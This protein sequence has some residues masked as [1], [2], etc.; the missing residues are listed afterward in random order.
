MRRCTIREEKSLEQCVGLLFHESG[1]LIS[2]QKEVTGVSTFGFKDATWMSTSLLCEQ[3]CQITNAKA[4]VFSDSVSCVGK[5]GDDSVATWKSKIKWYSEQSIQGYES[6]RWHADGVRVENI[7]RNHNVG[8][9]RGDPKSNERL[10][11]CT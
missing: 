10:T 3:A 6:N 9:P 2:E 5:M 8:P 11:V 7:P 4:Y 1:K